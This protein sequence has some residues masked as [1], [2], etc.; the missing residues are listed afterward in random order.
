MLRAAHSQQ[1][2]LRHHVLLQLRRALLLR[3]GRFSTS[4]CELAPKVGH[5]V[6]QRPH[7][8]LQQA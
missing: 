4:I 8:V 6:L 7:L 2:L 1:L 5:R 3:C